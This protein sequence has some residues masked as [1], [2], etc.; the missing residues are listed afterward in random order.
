MELLS[1]PCGRRI[2]NRDP[3]QSVADV[4]RSKEPPKSAAPEA[5]PTSLPQISTKIHATIAK[6]GAPLRLVG[7]HNFSARQ[8]CQIAE[9]LRVDRRRSAVAAEHRESRRSTDLVARLAPYGLTFCIAQGKDYS[10]VLMRPERGVGFLD[11]II[12]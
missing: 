1:L 11:L 10:N 7:T 5:V 8:G 9:H 4:L 2:P 12:G 6:A 3:A